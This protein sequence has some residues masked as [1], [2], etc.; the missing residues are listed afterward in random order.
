[1]PGLPVPPQFRSGVARAWDL[2]VG[3]AN[4][5]FAGAW[6]RERVRWEFSAETSPTYDFGKNVRYE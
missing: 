1:M 3:F 2:L 6:P 5:V 4:E